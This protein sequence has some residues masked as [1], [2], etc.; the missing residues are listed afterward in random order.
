M[1]APLVAAAL[2]TSA[3]AAAKQAASAAAKKAATNSITRKAA[4]VAS[5]RYVRASGRYL[6]EAER[7]GA[8]T[9]YGQLLVKAARRTESLAKE[10]SSVDFHGEVPARINDLIKES[11]NY[12][13]KSAKTADA[14]GDLLGETLLNGTMQG[15]RLFAVTREIWGDAGYENRYAELRAAFDGQNLA[16]IILQ[17]EKDTGVNIMKGD[18]NSQERYGTLT[19]AEIMKVEQYIIENYG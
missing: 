7:V 19:R 12:L 9:R 16:D 5:Q 10:I 17:I 14:R 3:G 2:R 8:R 1:V 15:H 6:K 18:I 11:E 13:V 4:R